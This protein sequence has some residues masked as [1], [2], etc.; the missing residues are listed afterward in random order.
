MKNKLLLEPSD[1]RPSFMDWSIAGV[2]NPGGVR[3]KNKEIILFVRIMEEPINRRKNEVSCPVIISEKE[4]LASIKTFNRK[5]VT[6]NNANKVYF[7]N[8][9]CK[10]THISH[11]R[12][13]TLDSTGFHIKKIENFPHF[14]G[15]PGES[16]YGVEDARITKIG[17]KYYM[18]YV[19][20]SEKNG[21]SSF[22]AV[23][24][25]LNKWKEKGMIFR[26]QNKD[27]VL[28]PEKIK[29]KYVALNR[30]ESSFIFSKS[31]IWISYSPDLT[32]WGKDQA[33]LRA[34]EDSWEEE[35][36]GAG[37]PPIKTKKGWLII[38][39]GFRNVR[40]NSKYSAGAALLDLKN[41]EK[42]LARS[43]ANKPLFTPDKKYEQKGF[44][45][46]VVFPTAAIPDLDKKSL[47]IYSGGADSIITVRKVSFNDIFKNMERV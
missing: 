10:L 22:L 27:V 8:G 44:M 45:N 12:R 21:A 20:V 5:E 25:D 19:G 41:P 38:Y 28:F 39:H 35:R 18:T 9:Q 26:E 2:L 6:S 43:P 7:K 32:Y 16:E 24:N 47:L 42:V 36:N 31:S 40:G 4:Y 13:V 34:R 17:N 23:S 37:P 1:F 11:F 29:G 15:R 3:T 46:N 14:V 33:L 30:P